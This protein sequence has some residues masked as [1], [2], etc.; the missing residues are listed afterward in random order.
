MTELSSTTKAV[1]DAYK[2]ASDGHYSDDG[3]WIQNHEAQ[4]AAALRAARYELAPSK[5]IKDIDYLPQAYVD[6]YCDALDEIL[7]LAIELEAH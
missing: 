7:A 6:G 3:E 4:I 5:T 1:L 2:D